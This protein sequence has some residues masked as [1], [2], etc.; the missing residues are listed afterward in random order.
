M[1]R[2]MMPRDPRESGWLDNPFAALQKEVNRIFDDNVHGFLD[3]LHRPGAVL[4]SLELHETDKTFEVSAELP[5][6]EEKDVQVT[7][8]KGL[9]TIRGEKKSEHDEDKDGYSV[10]ERSYGSFRRQLRLSGP[11]DE[12]KMTATFAKGVLKVILPKQPEAKSTE[13]KIAVQSA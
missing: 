12:A 11:V 3:A 7:F 5:G 1:N 6:V 9:L 8:D 10:S 4:P 13:K 2:S